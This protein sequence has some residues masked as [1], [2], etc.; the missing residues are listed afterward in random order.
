MALT[1]K[2]PK[3]NKT[4][5]P[6]AKKGEFGAKFRAWWNGV[7]Y[8]PTADEQTDGEIDANVAIPTE[9]TQSEAATESPKPEAEI[10]LEDSLREINAALGGEE[11]PPSPPEEAIPQSSESN[12]SLVEKTNPHKIEKN[13]NNAYIAAC[14]ILWGVGRLSPTTNELDD[15]IISQLMS[16]K[17]NN[18]AVFGNDLGARARIAAMRFQKSSAFEKGRDFKKHIEKSLRG[19]KNCKHF[20]YDDR[21]GSVP[22]N[23]ADALF[24]AFCGTQIKSTES[25]IFAAER[26]LKPTGEGV[27]LDF[28]KL[29][30]GYDIARCAGNEGRE[31]IN[32]SEIKGIFDAAGLKRIEEIDHTKEFLKGYDM[33]NGF[34]A[35]DWEMVQAKLMEWGGINAA[36]IALEQV[37]VWRARA[38]ALRSGHLALKKY[39]FARA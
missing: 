29:H 4:D 30:E 25:H 23:N 31:F 34:L 19:L 36:N 21:P 8:V 9:N 2:L 22:K 35:D 12:L 18:I 32:D 39:T 24:M 37:L 15:F 28:V 11:V 17:R 5:K 26:I 14:E 1:L 7:D 20:S 6:N 33:V 13:E 38:S 10:G 27:W 16:E 3:P